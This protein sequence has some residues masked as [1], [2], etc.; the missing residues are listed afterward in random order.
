MLEVLPCGPVLGVHAR[1]EEEFSTIRDGTAL[2][3]GVIVVEADGSA[4]KAERSRYGRGLGARLAIIEEM[5]RSVLDVG[6]Q[7]A[8]VAELDRLYPGLLA[9]EGKPPF[10]PGKLAAMALRDPVGFAT[11]AAVALAVRQ[12]RGGAE[13][14]RGR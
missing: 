9:R 1:N 6:S 14:T 2:D 11:Y 12:K 10:G 5:D 4:D 3:G 8:G 7:D 13:F